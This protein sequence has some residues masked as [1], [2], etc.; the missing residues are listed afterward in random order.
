MSGCDE[1]VSKVKQH[2]L[3]VENCLILHGDQAENT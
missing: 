1:Q 3:Q 2:C